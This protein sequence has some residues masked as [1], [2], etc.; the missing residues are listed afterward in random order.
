MYVDDRLRY[1][2]C[3]ISKVACTSWKRV[4][5]MLTG[6]M[7]VNRTVDLPKWLAHKPQFS[8]K[9]LDRLDEYDVDEVRQ[10]VEKYFKFMFV[11]HPF[12]RLV[13]AY[14][15]KFNRNESYEKNYGLSMAKLFRPKHGST[16]DNRN[17]KNSSSRWLSMS[18]Q[19]V[20]G[21]YIIRN[22]RSNASAASL[23]NG[24]DV[25]F[26]EFVRYLL[27][28]KTRE[29]QPFDRHW[30]SFHETCHPCYMR[31]DFIGKF[32]TLQEDAAY[33]IKMLG[34]RV[35]FPESDPDNASKT[36]RELVDQMRR[37]IS[38]E[39]YRKLRELYAFD[40]ELFG[41]D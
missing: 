12:E 21:S 36:S 7:R 22:Y 13:S 2:Y 28:P 15:D 8:A 1:I 3:L 10:R 30:L 4:T 35:G 23:E 37:N 40:Y 16:F 33:V 26:E 25:T 9:Y 18:Y 39:N 27:D 19:K 38:M 41:Y 29:K 5:L 11:R 32:E 17:T 6:R 20:F 24:N 14:R 31:Y 34:G